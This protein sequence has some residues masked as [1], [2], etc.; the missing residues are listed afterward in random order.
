[1]ILTFPYQNIEEHY[2][3]S[4]SKTYQPSETVAQLLNI[5]PIKENYTVLLSN[6]SFVINDNINLSMIFGDIINENFRCPNSSAGV[7]GLI[8]NTDA[9]VN[10]NSKYLL[11]NQLYEQKK[12]SEKLFYIAPYYK[13]NKLLTES[14]IILGS[15]PKEFKLNELPY[16]DLDN[17]YS[18]N[19]FDCRLDEIIIDD[20]DNTTRIQLYKGKH[21]VARFEEGNIQQNLLPYSLYPTFK[22]IFT[23]KGCEEKGMLFDCSNKPDVIKNFKVSYVFGKYKYIMNTDSL[24]VDNKFFFRF[25]K[26]YDN[27][28][29]LLSSFSG[30]FHRI[31]S[32]DDQRIYYSGVNKMMM[33]QQKTMKA[34]PGFI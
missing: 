23:K 30:N 34:K 28:V 16:C 14:K 19:Y 4:K 27:F 3:K 21:I 29:I 5:N 17:T 2:D 15:Y 8:R 7:A 11:I 6:E 26:E 25:P 20:F 31:Y 12:I 9:L 13:D 22:E 32:M 18:K 10:L 1:M 24:W 33:A